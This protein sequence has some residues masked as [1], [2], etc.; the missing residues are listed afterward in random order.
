[1]TVLLLAL[2][3][4]TQSPRPAERPSTDRQL[5]IDSQ[6]EEPDCAD[7]DRLEEIQGDAHLDAQSDSVWE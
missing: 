2:T 3:G 5:G 7:V 4:F 6:L 1:M